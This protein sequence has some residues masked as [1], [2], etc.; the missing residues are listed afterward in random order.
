MAKILGSTL[1]YSEERITALMVE[2]DRYI[3][4]CSYIR[5]SDVF[6]H[7]V[8][9]P[10][11]RFWVS[12]IRAAVVIAGM[13]KGGQLRNMRPSKREMFQEIF[14]RVC[15]LKAAHPSLPLSQLVAEVVSQPAPKFYLSP[16]S[17]RIMVYKAKKE[18][19]IKKKRKIRL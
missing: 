15:R 13:L 8:N 11:P 9:R 16:S 17:A 6:D 2:Y 1:E 19:F 14:R 5:M 7:I 10:C 12:D 4:S 18:W 3:A